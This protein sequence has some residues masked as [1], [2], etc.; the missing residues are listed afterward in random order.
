MT[1]IKT[2]FGLAGIAAFIGGDGM[3]NFFF[4]LLAIGVGALVTFVL[5]FIAFKDGVDDEQ[6]A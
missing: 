3:T 2:S 6:N 4:A 1:Y 5:T